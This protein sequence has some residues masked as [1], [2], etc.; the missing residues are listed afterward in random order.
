MFQI[1]SSRV[2]Q[3]LLQ[4]KKQAVFDLQ[5]T[6]AFAEGDNDK[7][8]DQIDQLTQQLNDIQHDAMSNEESSAMNTGANN[9]P[10]KQG[11]QQT[12]NIKD[13]AN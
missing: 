3:N 7:V 6:D 8:G 11:E 12:I 10:E 13:E 4:R 2:N 5:F 1:A 9:S